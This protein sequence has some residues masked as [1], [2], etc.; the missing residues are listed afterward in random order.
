MEAIRKLMRCVNLPAS[1]DKI[2]DIL[3]QISYDA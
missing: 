3:P 1:V 2:Y